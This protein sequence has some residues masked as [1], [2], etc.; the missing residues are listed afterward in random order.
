M[1]ENNGNLLPET[2]LLCSTNQGEACNTSDERLSLDKGN[3]LDF[4]LTLL[5]TTKTDS[6]MYKVVVQGTH[7]RTGGSTKIT[8]TIHLEIRK[9]LYTVL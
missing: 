9:R 3:G 7:P 2:L 5:N 8:K 6:G 4:I 1:N